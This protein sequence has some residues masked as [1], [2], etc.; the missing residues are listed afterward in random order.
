MNNKTNE[1]KLDMFADLL[2]PCA[3]ILGDKEVIEEIQRKGGSAIKGIKK[4]IKKHP[5]EMVEILAILDGEDPAT[6]E[7]NIAMIPVRFLKLVNDPSMQEVFSELF[8]LQGQSGI[9]ASSGSAMEST[10]DGEQ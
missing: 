10:Q 1:Q 9:S 3:A 2:E 7:V 8:S 4:A 6:Y 5:S